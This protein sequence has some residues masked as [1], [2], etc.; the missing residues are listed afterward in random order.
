MDHDLVVRQKVMEKYLLQELDAEQR[1]EFEEHFFECRECA[2]DVRA[3]A[4]FI[5]QS[6]IILGEDKGRMDAVKPISP[7]V[8]PDW[9]AWLRPRYTAGAI[10]LLLAVLGYQSLV[11][12][13]R[14]RQ[15][16]VLP[17]AS[18]NVGTFGGELPTITTNPGQGFLLFVRIPPDGGYSRKQVDLY[19]PSGKLEWSLAIPSVSGQDQFPVQVPGAGL[20]AGNYTLVVRGIGAAGETKEV[21]RKSFA[22]QIQ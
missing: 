15:P 20:A 18:L 8:K 12:Y 10:A 22:L 4:E 17:M 19:D 11:I 16:Q 1:D 7:P 13:P 3:G 9:F 5:E 6:Q 21:G 14:L 2:L